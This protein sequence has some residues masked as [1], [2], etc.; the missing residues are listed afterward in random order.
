MNPVY[1]HRRTKGYDQ[2]NKLNMSEKTTRTLSVVQA[3]ELIQKHTNIQTQKAEQ[4]CFKKRH[5]WNSD[6][7]GRKSSRQSFSPFGSMVSIQN[8]SRDSEIAP[9]PQQESSYHTIIH[10][11]GGKQH[12]AFFG[13]GALRA[14]QEFCHLSIPLQSINLIL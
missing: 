13:G 9:A 3:V 8:S 14:L 6:N 11:C 7:N 2:T 4:I 5:V 10:V 12:L 1:S